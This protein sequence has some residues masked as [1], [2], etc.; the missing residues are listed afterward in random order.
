M[1]LEADRVVFKS[2]SPWYEYEEQGYKPNT[3]RLL[4]P[5]ESLRLCERDP[6]HIWIVEADDAARCFRREV[7]SI[8]VLTSLFGRDLVMVCWE[9]EGE[10]GEA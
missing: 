7:R 9:H 5:S 8:Y 2:A 10:V 4:T 3:V 1:Q 6:Q